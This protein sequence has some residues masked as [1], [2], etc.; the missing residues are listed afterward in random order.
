[1]SGPVNDD[2][3]YQSG[4]PLRPENVPS[5]VI[6][7]PDTHRELRIPAGQSRT[8]KWPVLHYGH[9]PTIDLATWRFEVKGLV[10]S[11]LSFSWE[12]FQQ[13]PRVTVFSD[14]HCVTRWSRLGNYWEGVSVQ[15]I[16]R[17]AG[18]RP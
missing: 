17:L 7:S 9:V 1:M 12:E 14:F 6:I 18:V 4:A 13:L 15:E 3:K 8:R 16:M 10:N 11:P 5:G 2:P